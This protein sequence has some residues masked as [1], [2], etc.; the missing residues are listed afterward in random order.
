MTRRIATALVLVQALTAGTAIALPAPQTPGQQAPGL[1]ADYR[2]GA[3]DLLEVRVFDLEQ[4]DASVRVT[5]AGT[6]SLPMIGEL[7]ASGLTRVELEGEIEEAL[8]R[9]V[10]EPQVSVFIREYQSQRFSVI[11][12][13]RSPG[14]YDMVGQTTL[15]EALSMAGGIDTA[16][17][18]GTITVLRAGLSGPPLEIDL[19]VLLNEGNLSYNIEVNRGDTINVVPKQSYFIYVYGRVRQPGSY[20][21]RESVTLLQAISM[22]GGVADR[23]QKKKVRILRPARR[24]HAGTD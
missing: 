15:L 24:R 21:L 13:V 11:G 16:D 8:T 3:R 10:N 1:A 9:Y 20:E 12:A 19:D 18:A 17:A 7:Q 14:P 23:A 22:G 5:E 6:I 4:L 2:I